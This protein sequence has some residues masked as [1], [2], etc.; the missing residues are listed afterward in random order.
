MRERAEAASESPW[1]AGGAWWE[2]W[3][4]PEGRTGHTPWPLVTRGTGAQ[5]VSKSTS[6][7][8]A[9]HIASWRPAVAL[10]VADWLT[11]VATIAELVGKPRPGD[12]LPDVDGIAC[13]LTVAETYLA[14]NR[15]EHNPVPTS[16]GT[17]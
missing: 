3:T 12:G 11:A 5:I 6:D 15:P 1:S 17:L 4:D 14:S 13:A 16:G 7:P 8:D 2:H 9:A 10:A